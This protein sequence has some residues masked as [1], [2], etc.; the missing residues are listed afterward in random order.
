VFADKLAVVAGTGEQA[1]ADPDPWA[2]FT[3]FV[4]TLCALASEAM[5]STS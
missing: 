3:R 2:G 1:L 5:A 4:E